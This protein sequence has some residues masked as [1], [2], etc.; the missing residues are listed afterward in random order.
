MGVAQTQHGLFR[1]A[2]RPLARALIRPG[3]RAAAAAASETLAARCARGQSL[4][5]RSCTKGDS[6]LRDPCAPLMNPFSPP[7]ASLPVWERLGA[8]GALASPLVPDRLERGYFRSSV[9]ILARGKDRGLDRSKY[10]LTA[11]EAGGAW[12]GCQ[13]LPWRK[14]Q[15]REEGRSSPLLGDTP[16]LSSLLLSSVLFGSCP[17][18]VPS[19]RIYLPG[20]D[21]SAEHYHFFLGSASR[22]QHLFSPVA[23]GAGT[24]PSGSGMWP[25]KVPGGELCL[26]LGPAGGRE[27]ELGVRPE[28]V[29]Q[30]Q[31]RSL[32]PGP[33]GRA[34]Q[35]LSAP[36]ALCPVCSVGQRFLGAALSSWHPPLCP[37]SSL[38]ADRSPLAPTMIFGV[39]PQQVQTL[40]LSVRVW[41]AAV[42]SFPADTNVCK[43]LGFEDICLYSEDICPRACLC[44][45][46]NRQAQE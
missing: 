46:G 2:R 31:S 3:H 45:A 23:A 14:S 34:P 12:G 9:L 4:R 43:C 42:G 18:L 28:L 38:A 37:S 15:P 16:P 32:V 35:L 13:Y 11:K 10:F 6:S 8:G 17:R 24:W 21:S 30:L 33:A 25:G 27:A 39:P 29:R 26:C 36:G 19:D 41:A 1:A 22:F 20:L 40:A 5:Q 7:A 44:W